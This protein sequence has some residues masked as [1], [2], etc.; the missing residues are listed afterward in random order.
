MEKLATALASPPV[1]DALPDEA[2]ILYA[3]GWQ[4]AILYPMLLRGGV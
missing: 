4:I 1:S 2:E 3:F